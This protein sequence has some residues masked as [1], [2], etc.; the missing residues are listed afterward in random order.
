M[1]D[2][3][4][5][6]APPQSDLSGASAVNSPLD[7]TKIDL[8]AAFNYTVAR[9]GW[10]KDYLIA[11]LIMLVP[12]AGWAAFYGWMRRCFEQVRDGRG[13]EGPPPIQFGD[14]MAL[15]WAPMVAM[16]TTVFA[17]MLPLMCFMGLG[18]GISVGIG[19]AAGQGGG[20][21]AAGVVSALVMV[22]MQIFQFVISIG[23]N[24]VYPEIFRRGF[25]G[26]FVPVL[27]AGQS[28]RQIK[29]RP[30]LYGMAAL[31]YFICA[32]GGGLGV[33]ACCVG[34]FVTFPLAMAASAHIIAQW[35]VSAQDAL[36]ELGEA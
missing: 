33:M 16:F 18:M 1:S 30:K 17:L 7:P 13:G 12:I 3:Q 14:D 19:A 6:Y 29:A 34:W 2:S 32:M 15:G 25:N 9:E 26:E 31:G 8:G 20:G 28:F 27:N 23:I 5:P 35:N 24:L 36:R 10:W 22:A 11:G 4:S 21:G